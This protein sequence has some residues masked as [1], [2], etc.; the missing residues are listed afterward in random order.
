M[1]ARD[2]R[3]V[4]VD[5]RSGDDRRVCDVLPGP[6]GLHVKHWSQ[7]PLHNTVR[8][9]GRLLKSAYPPPPHTQGH[10]PVRSTPHTRLVGAAV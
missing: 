5:G 10:Y 2:G 6:G 4:V 8:P 7:T 1:F 9:A 3:A